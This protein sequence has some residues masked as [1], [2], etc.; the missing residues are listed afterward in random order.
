MFIEPLPSSLCFLLLLDTPPETRITGMLFVWFPANVG[1][2]LPRHREDRHQQ[3]GR[4]HHPPQDQ[5]EDRPRDHRSSSSNEKRG[6]AVVVPLGKR[7]IIIKSN[8]MSP[9]EDQPV[10]KTTN[11][12]G[13]GGVTVK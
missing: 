6:C 10:H 5:G 7:V 8:K 3:D 13:E 4:G 12:S 1:Q 2:D 11:Y 9:S